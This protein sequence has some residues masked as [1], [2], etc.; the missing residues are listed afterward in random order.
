MEN[1]VSP[2]FFFFLCS[3][4]HV[5]LYFFLFIYLFVCEAISLHCKQI[6]MIIIRLNKIE[7]TFF[8]NSK[9]NNYTRIGNE[10][11]GGR[12]FVTK[13]AVGIL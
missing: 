12:D 6:I 4:N 7:K 8:C 2:F 3:L 11:G 13:R 5:T 10:G 9:I 1:C